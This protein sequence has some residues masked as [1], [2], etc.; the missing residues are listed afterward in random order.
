MTERGARC[1]WRRADM[2]HSVR[3]LRHIGSV[4]HGPPRLLAKRRFVVHLL[5]HEVQD[6][7][8]HLVGIVLHRNCK[9]SSEVVR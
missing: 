4:S 1:P 7:E 8:E 5:L 6:V 3:A 9:A 2:F